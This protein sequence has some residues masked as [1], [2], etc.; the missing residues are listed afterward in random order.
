VNVNMKVRSVP[1][2]VINGTLSVL[3][4]RTGSGGN[5]NLPPSAAVYSRKRLRGDAGQFLRRGAWVNAAG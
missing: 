2:T 1:L 3:K 5:E 4:S